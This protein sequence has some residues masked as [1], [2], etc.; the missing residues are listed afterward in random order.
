MARIDGKLLQGEDLHVESPS[1]TIN[2]SN[3]TFTLSE[4]P[5]HSDGVYVFQDGLMLI[6]TTDYSVSGTTITMVTAP[7]NG[8]SLLALFIKEN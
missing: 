5:S 1:G 8:Q 4:T 7:A 6:P 2:G 3:V